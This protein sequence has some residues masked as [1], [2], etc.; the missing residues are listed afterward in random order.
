MSVIYVQSIVVGR[1]CGQLAPSRQVGRDTALC[2]PLE[3]E[4]EE[5]KLAAVLQAQ[6]LQ[7]RRMESRN[8]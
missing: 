6:L 4:K 8:A 5:L 1:T 7:I 3:C 2:A